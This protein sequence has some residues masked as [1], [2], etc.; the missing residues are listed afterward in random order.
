VPVMVV[1]RAADWLLLAPSSMA[2][3]FDAWLRSAKMSFRT[4]SWTA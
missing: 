1:R 3:H 4:D 2:E